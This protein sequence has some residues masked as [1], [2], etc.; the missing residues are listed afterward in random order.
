MYGIAAHNAHF[1][2]AEAMSMSLLPFAGASQLAAVGDVAQHLPWATIVLFTALLNARH[3]LYSASLAPRLRH[4]PRLRRACMAQV[5]TDEAFALSSGHFRRLGR[6][7]VPGYW[8]AALAAVF[9]PFN[10]AT[11]AGALAGGAIPDPNR[12]GLDVI[13]PAAMAG[14]AVGLT[15]ARRDIVAAGAGGVIGVVC[16]VTLGAGAGIVAGGL[17]GPAVALAFPDRHPPA[18]S[19]P[20]LPGTRATTGTAAVTPGRTRDLRSMP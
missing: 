6:V 19:D 17:L 11:L 20:D 16:T 2:V 10:L 14:L 9:I 1:S 7:D 15:T 8:V 5:L 4:V 3:L 13:F 18:A 12:F